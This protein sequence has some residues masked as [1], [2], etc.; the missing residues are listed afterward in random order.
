MEELGFAV[1]FTW[2]AQEYKLAEEIL[3]LMRRP[4]IIACETTVKKLIALLQRARLFIGSDTG[5]THIASCLEIP[6]VA[7]FGP[8]DPAIYS[9]YGDNTVVVRK[10][11]PCSPCT[12]RTCNHVSCIVS[13]TPGDVFEAIRK[14]KV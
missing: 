12:K 9:P 3:S 11:I 5:P 2:G 14:L 4:A 8:K 10:D 6:T 13:I 1:I 7:I